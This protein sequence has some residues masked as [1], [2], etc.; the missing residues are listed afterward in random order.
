MSKSQDKK[1]KFPENLKYRRII[2]RGETRRL[3]EMAGYTRAS[4]Y[5]V[6]NGRRRMTLKFKQAFLEFAREK[7]ELERQVEEVSGKDN[8]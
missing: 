2:K 5:E 3:A 6:L 1:M 8:L 7:E 4:A